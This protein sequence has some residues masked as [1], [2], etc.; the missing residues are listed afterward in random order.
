MMK[1]Y[2]ELILLPTF[3][4]RYEY[5]KLNGKVARE[6]FGYYR[7]LNQDFYNSTDWK[8]FRRSIIERDKA[9]DLGI[10]GLEICDRLTLHHINPIEVTDIAEFTEALMDP[11]NVICASYRTHKAIHYGTFDLANNKFIE[12]TANDTCPWKR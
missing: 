7:W 9:C 12:R 2:S 3:E 4:E 1:T 10:D 6:T 5:L 11:E 8:K